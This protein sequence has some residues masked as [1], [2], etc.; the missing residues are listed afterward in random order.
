MGIAT[1]AGTRPERELVDALLCMFNC[2]LLTYLSH[3]VSGCKIK[4]C[5]QVLMV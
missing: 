1:Q 4:A 5:A 3:L 2:T